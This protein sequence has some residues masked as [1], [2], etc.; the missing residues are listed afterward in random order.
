MKSAFLKVKKLELELLDSTTRKNKKRLNELLDKDFL[1]FTSTGH[2]IN[3]KDVLKILP[4]QERI[5]WKVF[6]IKIKELLKDVLIV[7]YK[8]KKHDLKNKN[9]TLSL[10]SS[11][12]K[13][14]NSNWQMVFH[15]G[16]PIK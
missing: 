13:N 3:K 14:I 11:I 8:V 15:Q 5:N 12:W 6:N 7:T 2:I 9:I 4:I 1:E 16:T 10:R